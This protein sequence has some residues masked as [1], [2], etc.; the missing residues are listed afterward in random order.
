MPQQP[1][2]VW[3]NLIEVMAYYRQ[4]I[5]YSHR[6]DAADIYEPYR[7]TPNIIRTLVDNNVGQSDVV[8]ATPVG[9]ASTKSSFST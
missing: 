9:A 7:Q 6:S 3:R 2:D 4:L 5:H 1:I 8:G